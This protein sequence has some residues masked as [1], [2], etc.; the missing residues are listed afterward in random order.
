MMIDQI[1][2]IPSNEPSAHRMNIDKSSNFNKVLS[3][4]MSVVAH[5]ARSSD[6]HLETSPS[7]DA[8]DF[9]ATKL[10][11]IG[12]ITSKNPTV[13]NLLIRNPAL[14]KDCWN[15]IYAQQ[16]RDKAYTCIPTGTDIYYDP[17]TKEL[18]W[19]DMMDTF[20]EPSVVA[21]ASSGPGAF[22]SETAISATTSDN[23]AVYRLAK[24]PEGRVDGL[25]ENL[26][27]TVKPMI[28][29][30]YA[31]MNCYE[32]LVNVLS[33]MGVQYYGRDGLG[34]RMVAGA[35]DKGLPINAYLNGEGLIRFS[36]SETY[37]KSFLRVSDPVGQARKVI[38]E[39]ASHLEKGSILSFSIES[40]GHAGI[41]S[42]KNG[43][44]TYINSGIM[45]NPV[46]KITTSKGVG[47]ESLDREIENWF[48]LAA[49]K[50]ESLV[51]TLGKLDKNKLAVYGSGKGH[52]V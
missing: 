39:M 12:T 51:I 30:T 33:K 23:N 6:T 11:K 36:G 24:G 42:S 45:D 10:V 2:G 40:Q 29:K 35:M 25:N 14:K 18:L 4:K 22:Q 37:R 16:N 1:S 5:N 46:D 27:D 21:S 41:I 15:I 50:N 7:G 19:G 9:S 3:E 52:R 8:P 26:V 48:R 34:R 32:L 20:A 49:R 44:W 38:Q 17:A 28:G 13:S 43:S 47:E 31:D